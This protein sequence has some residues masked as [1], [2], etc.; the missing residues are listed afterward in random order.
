[1]GVRLPGHKLREI[2]RCAKCYLLVKQRRCNNWFSRG[3][4]VKVTLRQGPEDH[5]TSRWVSQLAH[6]VARP[7]IHVC[8]VLS[9]PCVSYEIRDG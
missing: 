7:E 5:V 2:E 8:R 1:M 3:L 6:G 4:E 9:C